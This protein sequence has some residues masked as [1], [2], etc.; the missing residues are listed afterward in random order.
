M[1]CPS[2]L[3]LTFTSSFSTR[4]FKS[5]FCSLASEETLS[6]QE[7]STWMQEVLQI[8]KKINKTTPTR[9]PCPDLL[10]SPSV[11]FWQFFADLL[12]GSGMQFARSWG[13]PWGSALCWSCS[14]C[15]RQ[16]EA[17]TLCAREVA[18]RNTDCAQK[19]NQICIRNFVVCVLG[20][21]WRLE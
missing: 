6:Q 16:Q 20:P 14:S 19:W 15:A 13:C 1:H 2:S 9:V 7:Q 4:L 18:P 8:K 11:I 5:Y 3:K 17:H 21:C 10:F 12:K